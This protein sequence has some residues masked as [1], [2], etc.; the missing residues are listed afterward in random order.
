MRGERQ[1]LSQGDCVQRTH[2]RA[3][4]GGPESLNEKTDSTD[5]HRTLN[6]IGSK[7]ETARVYEFVKR[8]FD[9]VVSLF[10]LAILAP[11]FLIVM[12]FIKLEDGGPIFYRGLRIGKGGKPFFMLKFRTMVISADLIGGSLTPGI[13]D[14]RFS[15]I[16]FFLRRSKINELPQ[17]INVLLG[18]MSIVG[19]RP[20][21]PF[22]FAKY[23][24]QERSIV[25]IR[26]GITDFSSIEFSSIE[27]IVSAGDPDK[28]FEE[29]IFPRKQKLRMMY[30][31]ERSFWL[32]MRIIAMTVVVLT[33][34]ILGRKKK[35]RST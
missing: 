29:K 15:K 26:P 5:R 4:L 1:I 25:S 7:I 24:E 3:R 14:E 20:E 17:F 16:G 30:V 33:M 13:V 22:Y 6:M 21:H 10:S 23:S 31:Q 34:K 11:L 35:Q 28:I 2:G 12:L 9:L 18:E 19:P 27:E 32:D 8:I